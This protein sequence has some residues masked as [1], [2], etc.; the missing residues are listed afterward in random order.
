MRKYFNPLRITTY[1]LIL[2][3]FGHTRGALISTPRFGADADAVATAMR[4][5]HFSAQGSDATWYGFYLGFGYFVS[6]FFLLS[7][8]VTWFLGGLAPRERRAWTPIL[9]ALLLSYAGD[10]Y[11]SWRYFFAAPLAF[12]VAITALLGVECLRTVRPLPTARAATA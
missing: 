11:L 4:T 8:A 7:A 6:I 10:T 3:C 5:V 1:L 12:S 9:W 2:F